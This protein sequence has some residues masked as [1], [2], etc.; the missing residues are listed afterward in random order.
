M[1]SRNFS[2][3]H[4]RARLQRFGSERVDGEIPRELQPPPRLHQSK[5]ALREMLAAAVANTASIK[6]RRLPPNKAKR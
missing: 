5:D 3:E 6:I 4:E 1:S 2:R